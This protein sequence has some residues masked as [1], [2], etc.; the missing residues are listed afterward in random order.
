MHYTVI[1]NHSKGCKG[2]DSVTCVK[3]MKLG[4]VVFYK[5][6]IQN[7]SSCDWCQHFV[8]VKIFACKTGHN[9]HHWKANFMSINICRRTIP[10][11]PMVFDLQP[12]KYYLM[13]SSLCG[14]IGW[15]SDILY[16]IYH[17]EIKLNPD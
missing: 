4:I 7:F 10:W 5:I 8:L 3:S 17:R 9:V 12:F 11:K 2:N 13:T 14:L 15:I 16:D 6:L 1:I